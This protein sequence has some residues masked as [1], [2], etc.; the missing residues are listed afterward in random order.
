MKELV[1][2]IVSG[3]SDDMRQCLTYCNTNKEATALLP[4]FKAFGEE[5]CGIVPIEIFRN[6]K[7]IPVKLDFIFKNAEEDQCESKCAVLDDMIGE[8][9]VFVIETD[10]YDVQTVSV[11]TFYN[12]N[13]D[14]IKFKKKY[15][16]EARKIRDVT[17]S[18]LSDKWRWVR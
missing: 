8:N 11:T 4:L 3:K 12:A 1:Y 17:N 15:E 6:M 13:G 14:P 10:E 5:N 9:N 16:K 7:R 2:A 18:V